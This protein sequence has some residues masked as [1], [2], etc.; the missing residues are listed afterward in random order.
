MENRGSSIEN[1]G[2]EENELKGGTEGEKEKNGSQ[3]SKTAK[4]LRKDG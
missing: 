4:E 3:H 2:G 1:Y